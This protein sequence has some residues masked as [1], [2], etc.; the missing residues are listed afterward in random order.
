MEKNIS[1]QKSSLRLRFLGAA[2]TVTGSKYLL[3]NND[4]SI[5]IDCGLFQ[6]LKELRLQNWDQFPT[7]P[8]SI[9]AI[10]LTHA[11][12]DHSGYIPRLIKEG[13]AGKIFCTHA[14][15]ALCKILLIDAG[16]LQEEEAEWLNRKKFSKHSP[17]LPLFTQKEAETALEQFIPKNFDE[18][19]EVTKD[20][21]STF[22]YAGHILGAASAIIEAGEIKIAFSGDIGRPN[23]PILF[24]PVK[25]PLV[26]YL[27]VES[28]YGNRQHEPTDPMK[29]L[30]NVINEGLQKK[31]VILIPAFAVGRAQSLMF[32]LAELKRLGR[33]PNVP[34]YLNSP[35]A[36]NVTNLFG[37]FKSLHRLTEEQC[38]EMGDAVQY[39]RTVEESKALNEKKGPMIIISASGMA[40]GGRIVHHLKAFVSNP[41]T[42]VILAGFQAAGTRG[43]AL[44]DGAKEIKIHQQMIPVNASIRV[45]K[46]IS[47]HADYSEILDWLALSKI[48]PR[49]VFITHGETDAAN[50]MKEH[51]TERFHWPC[52][53]PKQ[54]QE[55]LL[56]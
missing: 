8:N 39:V 2:G 49:K 25:I 35:M 50:K 11:H 6:G 33:I 7:K 4:Q 46:N 29:D 31:G 52:E 24:P 37:E 44:Q 53:V 17:A 55:F 20:I 16:H 45:L 41:T 1:A 56:E 30:E 10:V 23:D 26:D 32:S 19:F 27:V 12:I 54:D 18:P 42:T 40:T 9:D 36:T 43:R 38:K 48:T 14:T 5:L 21:R 47:A 3:T 22:K 15:L 28:T 51:I 34:M 13:F